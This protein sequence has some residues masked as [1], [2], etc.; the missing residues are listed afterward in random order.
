[1]PGAQ[2]SIGTISCPCRYYYFLFLSVTHPLPAIQT[3]CLQMGLRKSD[4]LFPLENQGEKADMHCLRG[5]PLSSTIRE[6]VW[7]TR[8]LLPAGLGSL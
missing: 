5:T 3:A 4:P 8:M 6:G 2:S 1:M 7:G